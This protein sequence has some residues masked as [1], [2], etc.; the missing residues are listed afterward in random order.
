MSRRETKR[1]K[2]YRK[3]SSVMEEEQTQLPRQIFQTCMIE[4]LILQVP[5]NLNP[6]LALKQISRHEPRKWDLG[7]ACSQTVS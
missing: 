5:F 1:R 4:S 2:G 6:I 7:L 3:L